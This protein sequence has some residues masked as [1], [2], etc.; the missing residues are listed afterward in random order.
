[1]EMEEEQ[2]W[3]FMVLHHLGIFE[4]EIDYSLDPLEGLPIFAKGD[5]KESMEDGYLRYMYRKVLGGTLMV[6][7][8]LKLKSTLRTIVYMLNGVDLEGPT[9]KIGI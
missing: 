4:E 6:S 7:S 5:L 2:Q 1:M 8:K 3:Q 9:S